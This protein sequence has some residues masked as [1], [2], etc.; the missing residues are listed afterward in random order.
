MANISDNWSLY[1][2]TFDGGFYEN[3]TQRFIYTFDNPQ[4]ENL[5][6][7]WINFMINDGERITFNLLFDMAQFIENE[8]G[9]YKDF[10]GTGGLDSLV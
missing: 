5:Y 10:I 7:L 9:T 1:V 4:H 6:K 3:G 8:D 2:H